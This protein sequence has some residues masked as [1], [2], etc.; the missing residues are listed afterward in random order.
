MKRM[1]KKTVILMALLLSL[2][3]CRVGTLK[4]QTGLGWMLHEEVLIIPQGFT[5]Q[6]GE[7]KL[8]L[9]CSN[10]GDNI[11]SQFEFGYEMDFS[12]IE[13]YSFGVYKRIIQD[14]TIEIDH[15]IYPLINFEDPQYTHNSTRNYE[16]KKHSYILEDC[17]IV[18]D[19]MPINGMIGY[20]LCIL[21]ENG[22]VYAKPDTDLIRD[23]MLYGGSTYFTRD[24]S[25]IDF[26]NDKYGRK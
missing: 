18:D 26:S 19:K 10:F 2:A 1:F 22:E 4:F 6:K 5:H 13:H 12:T 23:N 8:H 3:S 17:F 7:A 20:Y 11:I 14:E 16:I 15:K 24:G 21:N 9:Y 25:T